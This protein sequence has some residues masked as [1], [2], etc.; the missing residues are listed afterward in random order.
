MVIKQSKYH[1]RLSATTVDETVS[2]GTSNRVAIAAKFTPHL[3]MK[4]NMAPM[5]W[6]VV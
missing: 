3:C 5:K 2:C 1:Q 4:H 6:V